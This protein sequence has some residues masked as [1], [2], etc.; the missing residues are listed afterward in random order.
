MQ[1]QQKPGSSRAPRAGRCS[2]T[3]SV[4]SPAI[5]VKL[6]RVLEERVVTRVGGLKPKELDVRFVF[7][8]NRDLEV[9]VACRSF[10]E[11]LY[12]RINGISLM[13]PPLRERPAE[14]EPLAYSFL[15]DL[16]RR[17]GRATPIIAPST[18]ALLQDYAWPGN[19]R[20]LRNVIERALVLCDSGT[21]TPDHL[22]V[23]K[24]NATTVASR[25]PPR[26]PLPPPLPPSARAR[27]PRRSCLISRPI[28]AKKCS[29]HRS[30]NRPNESRGSSWNRGSAPRRNSAETGLAPT[31][32]LTTS[33]GASPAA[34]RPLGRRRQRGSRHES[35]AHS[36]SARTVRW[37][38]NPSRGNCSESRGERW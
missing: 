15:A 13:I 35:R 22:P 23:E 38:S 31:S 1:R 10:R 16:C 3:K 2:S 19:I 12:F 17:S 37:Q 27:P 14:I 20:E 24:L 11:D 30:K 34:E 7:A 28:Y 18:L 5:Q 33:S 29:S 8:T 32:G 21:I 4:I 36:T 6:L 25:R 9:E 26:T